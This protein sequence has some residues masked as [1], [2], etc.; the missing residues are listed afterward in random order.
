MHVSCYA[1]ILVLIKIFNK[2]MCYTYVPQNMPRSFLV[3]KAKHPIDHG[4]KWSYK[5]PSSPTEGETAPSPCPPTSS[6]NQNYLNF[7]YNGNSKSFYF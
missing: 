6:A 2:R 4:G 5:Q 1:C 3:K 7:C